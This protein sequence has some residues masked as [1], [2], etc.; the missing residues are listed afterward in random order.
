MLLCHTFAANGLTKYES[1]SLANEQAVIETEVVKKIETEV[2]KKTEIEE[3]KMI[4]NTPTARHTAIE[5]FDYAIA[6]P[7]TGYKQSSLDFTFTS[8]FKNEVDEATI[9]ISQHKDNAINAIT[10]QQK[11]ELN[12]QKTD[13]YSINGVI[14]TLT[15]GIN[16]RGDYVQTLVLNTSIPLTVEASCNGTDTININKL[17][18]SLLSIV[19]TGPAQKDK[20]TYSTSKFSIGKEGYKVENSGLQFTVLTESGDY[21]SEKENNI[22]N[23]L[24]LANINFEVAKKKQ[25]KEADKLMK[26]FYEKDES[27]IIKSK[28][29]D[30]NGKSGF[31]YDLVKTDDNKNVTEKSYAIVIY[32]EDHLFLLYAS[33]N[34]NIDANMAKLKKIA[35]TLKIK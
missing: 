18:R 17:E 29:I 25:K 14:A 7:N 6:L 22:K 12:E 21:I 20:N 8:I 3:V 13:T 23:F 10:G 16:K 26:S 15:K 5:N 32:T 34:Q 28:A 24:Q 11:H 9:T 1:D 35:Q 19:Y 31:E 4:F 33:A 30:I 27:K 2:V